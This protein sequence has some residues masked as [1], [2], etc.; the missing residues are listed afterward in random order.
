MVFPHARVGFQPTGDEIHTAGAVDIST[1]E[2][3]EYD[4]DKR[5]GNAPDQHA[6]GGRVSA[7]VCSVLLFL[8]HDKNPPFST[9]V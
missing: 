2:N 4:R 6:D 8:C 5:N 9:C 7:G 1:A 3:D